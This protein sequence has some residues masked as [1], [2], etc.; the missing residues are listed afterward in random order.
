MDQLCFK[1]GWYANE[2]IKVRLLSFHAPAYYSKYHQQP[3]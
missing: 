1:S 2:L 3:C